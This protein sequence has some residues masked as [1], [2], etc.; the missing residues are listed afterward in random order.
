MAYKFILK[1]KLRGNDVINTFVYEDDPTNPIGNPLPIAQAIVDSMVS[2]VTNWFST[3]YALND[4]YYVDPDLGGGQP[5]VPMPVTG[6]PLAGGVAQPACANQLCLLLNWRCL[7]NAPWRGRTSLS[8]MYEQAIDTG[9]TWEAGLLSDA[10]DWAT[11]MLGLTDG[12]GG[13]A[14][15]NIR[16][17][18]SQ[19]VPVGT[20]SLVESASANPVPTTIRTRRLGRGS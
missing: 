12:L 17:T 13:F 6:L 19:N 5:A 4:V 16:S 3:E 14:Y 2:L 20:L 18:G 9:G 7:N 11:D 8:G 10:Q 15:L 1:Q